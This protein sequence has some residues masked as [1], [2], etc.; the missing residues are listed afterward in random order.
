MKNKPITGFEEATN[1]FDADTLNLKPT[2]P[3]FFKVG[4]D[5]ILQ[6]AKIDNRTLFTAQEEAESGNYIIGGLGRKISAVDFEAF[7]MG[8]AQVLY[9]Q[10]YQSG[11]ETENTGI[12]KHVV[13]QS[14]DKYG[15]EVVVSLNEL[16]RLSY[17]VDEPSKQQKEAMTALLKTLHT[18]VAHVAFPNGDTLD[19][20]LCA[21]MNI[22]TRKQDNAKLYNLILNPIF[23]SRVAT[24]YAELP[25]DAT[26]R[27]TASTDRKT[28]SHYLL[29]SLLAIQDR[30][31]PCKRRIG[32]LLEEL[33]LTDAYKERAS[34][35]EKQLLSLFEDM[36][37][38]GIITD[39]ITE[40]GRMGRRQNAVISVTFTLNPDF[41][42]SK[43]TE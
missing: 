6:L 23:C 43:S 36:K 4:R 19:V 1:L 7:K 21:T 28:E 35:T 29:F 15:G 16:C 40:R 5:G 14:P 11:H 20:T 38:T 13:K 34:R 26:K 2:L 27:L 9:N 18:N 10:S 39:F 25:Q 3:D 22:F 32:T 17:G 42:K 31:K 33:R 8:I 24:N 12:Q 41:S 30:R 37:K